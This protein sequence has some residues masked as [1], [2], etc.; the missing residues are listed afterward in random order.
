MHGAGLQKNCLFLSGLSLGRI[1][2]MLYL[3]I[4]LWKRVSMCEIIYTVS[5]MMDRALLFLISNLYLLPSLPF[6]LH[7]FLHLWRYS[8]INCGVGPYTNAAGSYGQPEPC[9]A[10]TSGIPVS[11]QHWSTKTTIMRKTLQCRKE[12][13]EPRLLQ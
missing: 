10:T 6:S 13:L 12:C 7:S 8:G 9:C 4:F 2:K 1:E 5:G 3:L 11:W